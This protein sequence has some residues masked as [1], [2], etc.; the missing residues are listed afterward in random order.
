M[1]APTTSNFSSWILA[2]RPKTLVAGAIPV[3]VGSLA[4]T[5][6]LAQVDW[7]IV[8]SALLSSV[9]LT[10]AV[11][12]I[13]DALD[14]KKGA[15]TSERIGPIRVTQSGLLSQKQVISAGI[16][17][18]ALT[19]IAALPLILKGGIPVLAFV[20]VSLLCSYLYTG[21]PYPLS[22]NGLGELFVILFY[23]FG[24]VLCTYYLQMGTLTGDAF[25]AS[26]QIGL[27]ATVLIAINNLRD[28]QEDTK[29]GKKTLAVRFGVPFAK[30]ELTLLIGLPFL[31]NF[32]WYFT[33]RF[34]AFFL[35]STALLIGINLARGIWKHAPSR[36]Y[37]RYLG[38]ASL[39]LAVFGILLILGLHAA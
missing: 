36:L 10:I 34:L 20:L 21:G 23:G 39:L 9:L 7:G 38:E 22:Y 25:I 32:Y 12:L 26:L 24:A 30:A 15:D 6:P 1:T 5:L 4:N 16:A 11:N 37:N 28:V 17:V 27:L 29:T 31:L 33:D 14:S 13:N 35:P 18:L 19:F 2:F 8:I 3:L